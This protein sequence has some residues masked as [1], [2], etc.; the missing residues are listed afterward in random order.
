MSRILGPIL[1]LS[2]V[3]GCAGPNA[4]TPPLPRTLATDL[5][6]DF[7]QADFKPIDK[8]ADLPSDLRALINPRPNLIADPDQPFNSGCVHVDGIPSVRLI[9]GGIAGGLGFGLYESGGSAGLRQ[10]LVLVRFDADR[11]AT[12]YCRFGAQ[13]IVRTVEEA[14]ALVPEKLYQIG[15]VE[16]R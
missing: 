1:L 5:E 12:A 11:Q 4:Y 2:V 14:K 15:G 9:A 16:C 8:V 10:S 7:L 6:R 3:S 13:A